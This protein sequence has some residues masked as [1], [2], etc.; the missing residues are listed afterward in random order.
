LIVVPLAKKTVCF[1]AK[2]DGN[3]RRVTPVA[4]GPSRALVNMTANHDT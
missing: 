1:Y 2:I 3:Y 4:T